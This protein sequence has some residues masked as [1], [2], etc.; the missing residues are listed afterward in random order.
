MKKPIQLNELRS[1]FNMLSLKNKKAFVTGAGGGI[2]R[3]SAAALAELGADVAIMDI[4]SKQQTL[5]EIAEFIANKHGVQVI[6]VTGDVSNEESVQKMYAEIIDKFGTVDIVHSNAGI[7]AREDNPDIDLAVWQRML[8]INYTGML[9]VAREGAKIMKAHG[10]GG[11]VILT[12]SISAHIINRKKAGERYTTAYTSTKA[13]VKHLAQALAMDYV[14]FNIR[15]NSISPGYICSGIHD[16][17]TEERLEY[18]ASSVPMKRIGTLDEVVGGIVYL[19]S[20]LSSYQT[21]SD[22]VCDGGYCVW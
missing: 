11:S 14:N 1:I 6:A 18:M 5:D 21:G 3:S 13:A 12:A 10:H 16:E 19:A 20:D 2:G 22:I 15:V 17:F 4:P 9:I 7:I 8:N